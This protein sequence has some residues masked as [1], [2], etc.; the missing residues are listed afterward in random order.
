MDT[1]YFSNYLSTRY[2]TAVNWY[3]AK[4]IR[5]K[6]WYYFIQ[7][8]LITLSAVTP[9]LALVELKWPTTITAS[10]VAILTGLLKFLQLQENWL[11]YRAVCETLRK[12]FHIFNADIGDYSHAIDKQQ[13]F[14]DRVENVISREHTLWQ[15]SV[16]PK[17]KNN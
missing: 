8:S 5:N 6:F 17:D 11:N 14:V 16:A 13:L 1:Q 7:T 9:I 4:S 2:E 15:A 10:V 3:D 12:E